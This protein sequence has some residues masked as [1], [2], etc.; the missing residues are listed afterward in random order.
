MF[1]QLI[2]LL[3]AGEFVC[4]FTHQA[5]YA[6]LSDPNHQANVDAYLEKI[7][8]KLVQTRHGG[9]FFCT[10]LDTDV[11]GKKSAQKTF[12][13]IKQTLRPIVTFLELLMRITQQDDILTAGTLLETNQV[14]KVIDANP[15]LRNDLQ[16]LTNQAGLRAENTDRSR[17]VK[18]LTDFCK[19]GYLVLVNPEREI[20]RVTGKIEYIMEVIEFLMEHEAVSE[21]EE[22]EIPQGSLL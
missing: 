18:I 19:Q 13:D 9:A 8:L 10:H 21:V 11:D 15:S 5:A 12:K 1:K 6:Y 3:L 2:P 17:L 20:Y 7:G 16:S 14:M 4:Q 22:T